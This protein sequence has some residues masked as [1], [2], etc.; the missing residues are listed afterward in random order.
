MQNTRIHIFIKIEQPSLSSAAD[1]M[2]NS[3][4][5]NTITKS[6]NITGARFRIVFTWKQFSDILCTRPN[7]CLHLNIYKHDKYNIC[8]YFSNLDYQQIKLHAQLS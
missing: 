4:T 6:I 5:E 1:D 7:N 8:L 3:T 2:L